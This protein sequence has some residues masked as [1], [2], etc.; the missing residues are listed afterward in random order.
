[1]GLKRLS[2]WGAVRSGRGV[3]SWFERRSFGAGAR[4]SGAACGPAKSG[5]AEGLR[6]PSRVFVGLLDA[7]SEAGS[8]AS[9]RASLPRMASSS[10][11]RVFDCLASGV[12][13]KSRTTSW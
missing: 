4:G 10:L 11:S 7:I 8:R 13:G 5:R 12:P 2:D 6:A 9:F 1:M 3:R